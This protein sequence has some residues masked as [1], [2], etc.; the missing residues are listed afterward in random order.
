MDEESEVTWEDSEYETVSVVFVRSVVDLKEMK[1]LTAKESAAD[2]VVVKPKSDTAK[3][4][5]SGVC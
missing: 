1:I 5:E 4:F 3:V 2:A